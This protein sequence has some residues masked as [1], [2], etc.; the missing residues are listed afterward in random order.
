MRSVSMT[1]A[2]TDITA[3]SL[4]LLLREALAPIEIAGYWID[5]KPRDVLPRGDGHALMLVPGF[6]FGEEI[7]RPLM[8]ALESLGYTVYGWGEGRNFGMRPQI[9]RRLSARLQMLNDRHR[10]KVSLIGWSLGGVFVRE[11]ARAQPQLVR[12]VITIGSPTHGYEFA[13][14]LPTQI[15]LAFRAVIPGGNSRKATQ[16]SAAPAVPCTAIYSRTDGFVNWRASIEAPAPNSE[17]IEVRASHFGLLHNPEVLRVIADRLVQ[18]SHVN[19]RVRSSRK[20]AKSH[21]S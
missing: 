21:S 19:S 1:K 5:S 6:G 12:R 9:R 20:P 14:D 10:G 3:S 16:R 11:L 18:K 4:K 7:L 15:A 17:N 2:S 8:G 13:D